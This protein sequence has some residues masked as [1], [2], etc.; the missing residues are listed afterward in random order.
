[1][2]FVIRWIIPWQLIQQAFL[3]LSTSQIRVYFNS[4]GQDE[5]HRMDLIALRFISVN[6]IIDPWVFILLSPSVLHFFWG[7]ICQHPL[8]ISRGSV[9]KSSL[10]KENSPAHLELSQTP[11][12]YPQHFQSADSLWPKQYLMTFLFICTQDWSVLLSADVV[13]PPL[14]H[15]GG[16]SYLLYGCAFNNSCSCISDKTPL[17][18][19]FA[20]Y[21][22]A[23]EWN[24][25]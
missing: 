23:S 12:D 7:S 14:S 2:D 9:F 1:M 3:P 13:G 11:A 21:I 5:S 18:E 8:A 16:G 15:E 20:A 22:Y 6:S 10:A 4:I 19:H 25:K 17:T 24:E